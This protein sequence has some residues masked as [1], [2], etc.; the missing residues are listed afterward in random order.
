MDLVPFLY[1]WLS[2]VQANESRL[3]IRNVFRY[4]LRPSSWISWNRLLI[5][6]RITEIF[7]YNRITE[8]TEIETDVSQPERNIRD[9]S[10]C[11]SHIVL[12]PMKQQITPHSQPRSPFHQRGLILI[13]AW[14]YNHM[15]S[16]VWDGIT[17]PFPNF[18]GCTAKICNHMPSKVW[19]EITY[20]FPNSTVAPHGYVITYLSIPQL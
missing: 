10:M 17:Y 20:P 1:L 16:K 11:L 3:Y 7:V 4:W 12:K 13:P 2:K 15:P 5:P 14:I 8:I 18:N 6:A 9:I 19:D